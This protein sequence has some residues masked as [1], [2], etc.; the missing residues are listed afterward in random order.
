MKKLLL[1]VLALLFVGFI[2]TVSVPVVSADVSESEFIAMYKGFFMDLQ[3]KR[4]QQVWDVMT[5]SSK[6][7]IAKAINDSAIA[8][9]KEST[10]AD[11]LSRLE[12]NISNLRT[13][14]FDNLNAE[15]RNISF[16]PDIMNALYTLKSASQ[17]RVV[18]TISVNNA[19]K[20]F[21]IIREAGR[22]KINFF[23][24]LMR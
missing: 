10:Q 6:N 21:L 20:E 11:V 2:F 19:P 9:N 12:N 3:E 5:L 23:E 16:Y 17:E 22:W 13:N 18:I 4:Y 7:A 14:Y 8:Q 24:D 15:F 1:S